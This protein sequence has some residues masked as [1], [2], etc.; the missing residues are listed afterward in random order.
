MQGNEGRARERERE[1]AGC[2][3][4]S[5]ELLEEGKGSRSSIKVVVRCSLSERQ[6]GHSGRGRTTSKRDS[7][8]HEVTNVQ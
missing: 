7:S 5:H 6:T 2:W 4:H 8:A 1:R 3:E